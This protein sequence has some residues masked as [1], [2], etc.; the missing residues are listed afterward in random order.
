MRAQVYL[1]VHTALSSEGSY[2]TREEVEDED[3]GW[4]A[5]QGGRWGRMNRRGSRGRGAGGGGGGGQ[6]GPGVR[7]FP[8]P[9]LSL[10]RQ[11]RSVTC[12]LDK[13]RPA[14][15]IRPVCN[16]NGKCS[17]RRVGHS[18]G[19]LCSLSRPRLVKP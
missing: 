14:G 16:G 13:R 15:E 17:C 8:P 5:R 18:P 7:A 10:P 3:N 9:S 19:T 4:E 12:Q 6:W 2:L 11:R 1:P